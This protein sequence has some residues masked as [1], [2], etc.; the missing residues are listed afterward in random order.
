MYTT[1]ECVIVVPLFILKTDILDVVN[2]LQTPN[3]LLQASEPICV[4][5]S[6]ELVSHTKG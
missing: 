3:T 2:A 4:K 6:D 5:S 1:N